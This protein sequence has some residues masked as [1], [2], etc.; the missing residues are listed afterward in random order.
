[1]AFPIAL[2]AAAVPSLVKG[3]S[4]L[5][6]IGKGNR[7][8]KRNV[9][10][11]EQVNPLIAQNAA[12]AENMARTGLPQEQ[13]NISNQGLQRNLSAGV[14]SLGRSANPSAGLASI[15][16]AGNDAVLNLG[17]Q[18]AQAR[19]QNQR[20]AFGQRAQLANEQNRVFD[21]NQRRKFQENAQAA[22]EQLNTGRQNAFGS[23]TD[24]SMLAQSYFGS[25]DGQN[26][27][28][29]GSFTQR[30]NRNNSWGRRAV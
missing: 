16:R 21:W 19:M 17:A 11:V 27:G 28:D 13:F 15:V 2:A 25:Q 12:M 18:D 14:R 24:A 8:A 4:G 30:Y 9:R 1:M 6:G 7:M 29:N 23:L 22:S 3:I 5:L 20:F 10:P 26:G